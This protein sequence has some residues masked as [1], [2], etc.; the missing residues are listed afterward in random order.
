MYLDIWKK[1]FIINGIYITLNKIKKEEIIILWKY[2]WNSLTDNCLVLW[3]VFW[4]LVF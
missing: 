4:S 1:V 2:E 3:W